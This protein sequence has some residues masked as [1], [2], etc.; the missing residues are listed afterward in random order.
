MANSKRKYLT[1]EELEE[2]ADITV[3]DE[4]EAWDQISQAEDLIDAYVGPQTKHVDRVHFGTLTSVNSTTLA[5]TSSDSPLTQYDDNHFSY[6]VIEII[7]GS[8]IGQTG[9][10]VASDKSAGTIT[11][12]GTMAISLDSTSVYKV[13]QLG[14]FPRLADVYRE[15]GTNTAYKSIPDAVRRAVA[16]QVQFIIE[17]GASYFSGDDSE[18]EAERIGNY[19]YQRSGA[20]VGGQSSI[21]KLIA[22]KARV[23]L[24]GFKRRSVELQADNPTWL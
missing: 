12:D 6:C 17:K 22:P 7:G 14:K 4:S 18:M 16:A 13:Y 9:T 2:Y 10:I 20:G 24:A 8:G 15:Q 3:T 11:L 21:V 5:D 1:I 19:S 23:L